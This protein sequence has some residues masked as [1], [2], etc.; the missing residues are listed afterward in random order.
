MWLLNH[1][2]E[3]LQAEAKRTGKQSLVWVQDLFEGKLVSKTTCLQCESGNE[4]DETFMALSVDIEKGASL[5][6]CIR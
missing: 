3:E 1:V 2:A 4:R 5:N 6:H